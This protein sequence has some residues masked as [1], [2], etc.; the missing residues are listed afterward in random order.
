MGDDLQLQHYLYYFKSQDQAADVSE[1]GAID[2]GDVDEVR[3][4][5]T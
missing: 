3:K 5:D 4:L 1:G 2:L